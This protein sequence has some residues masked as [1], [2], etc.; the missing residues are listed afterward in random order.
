MPAA[1]EG[2]TCLNREQAGEVVAEPPFLLLKLADALVQIPEFARPYR[3]PV[4]CTAGV[5]VLTIDAIVGLLSD[6]P[7]RQRK[8]EALTSKAVKPVEGI[9]QRE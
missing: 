6:K 4:D 7:S 1:V 3:H 8:I 9:V 2:D 5:A